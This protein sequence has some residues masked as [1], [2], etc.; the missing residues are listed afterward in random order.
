VK[1]KYNTLLQLL[2]FLILASFI[3][4]SC[5]E[6]DQVESQ[7]I[8]EEVI[9][10]SGETV[11][12]IARVLSLSV[13]NITNHGFIIDE[14]ESFADPITIELGTNDK[15]GRYIG[16]TNLLELGKA[17]FCKSFIIVNGETIYGNVLTFSSLSP[18]LT[19][20]TPKNAD[21]GDLIEVTGA[22]FTT[23]TRVF[24][25]E[26]EADIESIDFE[27]K[28]VVRVPKTEEDFE[29]KISVLI[30]GGVSLE[31]I[32]D[33]EYVT[34]KWT[35]ETEFFNTQE[36]TE[37]LSL[38]S[39]ES[40]YFGLG[41]VAG[42]LNTELWKL[43]LNNYEWSTSDFEASSRFPFSAGSYFGGGAIFF[44][45]RI[46]S[47][48]FW[49]HDG[50]SFEEKAEMPLRLYK[51]V[52]I[53]MGNDI[54]VLGGDNEDGSINT[55]MYNYNKGTDIWST[56]SP[57]P[58]SVKN[59][60]PHFTY[61]G[62]L[63]VLNKT[64]NAIWEYDADTQVWSYFIDLP[65]SEAFGGMAVTINGEVFVGLFD[66]DNRIWEL[67]MN[68]VVWKSKISYPNSRGDV[69]NGV[70]VHNNKVF[71]LKNKFVSSAQ[72]DLPMEIWSFDPKDL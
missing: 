72:D 21:V 44:L 3:T 36:Y 41:K 53:E 37:T 51:S 69:N 71:I 66:L 19:D 30:K 7:V 32:Q 58:F 67:D 35:K 59:P 40:L 39:G 70:F 2:V 42:Q 12:V 55:L 63:Y 28:I 54:I 20:F 31:F 6:D 17:Y 24:F 46:F 52:A 4:T 68:D 9:Y 26:V 18:F 65:I 33:F 34:G 5:T 56:L 11:R 45:P 29:V 14:S 49:Y 10:V 15:L 8:T 23:D 61:E 16:E 43:D 38:L 64:E 48:K 50:V 57:C 25:G 47:S 27:S 22:N 60:T 13:D 62:N 1:N